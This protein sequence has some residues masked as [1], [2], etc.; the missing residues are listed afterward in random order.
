MGKW[1]IQELSNCRKS[2]SFKDKELKCLILEPRGQ[3]QSAKAE[4]SKVL[5][6]R[7][8]SPKGGTVTIRDAVWGRDCGEEMPWLLPS[9]NLPISLL[10]FPM[11]ESRWRHRQHNLQWATS[12]NTREGQEKNPR[13][14]QANTPPQC[15][16]YYTG[17]RA[18]S[19][20]IMKIRNRHWAWRLESNCGSKGGEVIEE[21]AIF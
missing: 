20:K 15:A 6:D 4:G 12:L 21:T 7:S 9:F 16:R 17:L 18:T 1:G 2:L 10:C 3:S 5:C 8:W 14:Q 13:G 19:I 11:A